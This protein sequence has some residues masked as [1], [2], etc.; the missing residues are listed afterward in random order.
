LTDDVLQSTFAEV[1][2]VLKPNGKFIGT[3]PANETCW[4]IVQCV[5]TAGNHFIAGVMFRVFHRKD[6]KNF[7]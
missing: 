4:V 5:L 2:R 7:L 1:R 3:V 6:F